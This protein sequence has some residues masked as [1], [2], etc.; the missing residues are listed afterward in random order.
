MKNLTIKVLVN[1]LKT[2]VWWIGIFLALFVLANGINLLLGATAIEYRRCEKLLPVALSMALTMF[3][4]ADKKGYL[5]KIF[6]LGLLYSNALLILFLT[7]SQILFK[8]MCETIAFNFSI[9]NFILLLSVLLADFRWKKAVVGF[10]GVVC[11][12]P[13]AIFWAYYSIYQRL[14]A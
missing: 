8:T 4:F 9:A 3:L 10:S 5:K 11:F 13:S 7:Q 1:I 2:T 6:A 14:R 12:L